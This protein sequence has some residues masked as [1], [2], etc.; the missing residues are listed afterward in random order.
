ME[1]IELR[2][3]FL[4]LRKRI[5]IIILIIILFIA[6]SGI[7]SYFIL[8]PQYQAYT[9]LMIGKP[10]GYNEKIE[11][12]D[13]L[14]NQKLVT[15]YSEI[16][17]SRL[18]FNELTENLDLTLTIKEL[19]KKVSVSLLKDTEIIKIAVDDKDP[20]L[21]FN[22]ANEISS[23]FM[24]NVSKIMKVENIQ[25]IDKAQVPLERKKP[26]PILNM[27][28]AGVLGVMIGVFLVFFLEYLNNTVNTPDDIQNYLE[29]P[30][31]GIIPKTS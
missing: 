29:L 3:I 11:Y 25:I 15:T 27:T 22:M 7:G 19:E 17:K 9:T 31:I 20:K 6:T 8:E 18:I 24:K 5:R 23:V 12:S 10:Q 30:V 21:A 28:I 4:I 26:K 13:I 14:L 16:A 2:E 1:E